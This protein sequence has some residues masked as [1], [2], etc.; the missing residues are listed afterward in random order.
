M[1]ASSH[2]ESIRQQL[3]IEIGEC[4]VCADEL[5]GDFWGCTP[6][7]DEELAI[8]ICDFSGHGTASAINTF[9]FHTLLQQQMEQFGRDPAYFINLLNRQMHSLLAV[10]QFA[11][12]FYG[13]IHTALDTLFYAATGAPPPLLLR[14]DNTN[15]WLDS[16]GLPLGVV[17]EAN[18]EVRETP[19][20]PGDM[21][22]C[23]SDS[24]IEQPLS[25][26]GLLTEDDIAR[27]LQQ[28]R[29]QPAQDIITALIQP[30]QDEAGNLG[31]LNDDLTLNL[32]RRTSKSF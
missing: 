20:L 25:A 6:L 22:L 32:Y 10:D 7:S 5:G 16:S 2:L 3:G 31:T 15:E 12:T 28:R 8:Y 17:T 14:A 30:L 4:F 29:A 19:F 1:P 27:I 26:G 23:Y 13:V 9:R 24:L 11:T 18:Y 21:L